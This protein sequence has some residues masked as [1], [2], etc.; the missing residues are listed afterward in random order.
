[1]KIMYIRILLCDCVHYIFNSHIIDIHK[2]P[3]RINLINIL[4]GILFPI[5]RIL[6]KYRQLFST[7]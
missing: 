5:V 6:I 3:I 7:L 4:F 2:L 1:M